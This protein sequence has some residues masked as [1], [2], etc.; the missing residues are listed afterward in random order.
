MTYDEIPF[1]ERA[2]LRRKALFKLEVLWRGLFLSAI[3]VLIGM[4]VALSIGREAG[5]P[6]LV[7]YIVTGAVYSGLWLVFQETAIEPRIKRVCEKLKQAERSRQHSPLI[8][9]RS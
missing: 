2:D 6:P 8:L 1:G 5:W 7:R 3:A 4:T 9:S